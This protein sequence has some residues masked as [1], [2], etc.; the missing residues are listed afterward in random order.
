MS[1]LHLPLLEPL[2]SSRH[3]STMLISCCLIR[4]F[5]IIQTQLYY[6][7]VGDSFI[8]LSQN[9]K[10]ENG[11][12]MDCGYHFGCLQLFCIDWLSIFLSAISQI[13][14]E[15]KSNNMQGIPTNNPF[16]TS[17]KWAIYPNIIYA[18]RLVV[19]TS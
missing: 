16:V 8:S 19:T 15:G 10:C 6:S 3:H 18:R 12:C 14:K 17:T 4:S 5:I 1:E 13:I 2:L 9:K 11:W 7:P